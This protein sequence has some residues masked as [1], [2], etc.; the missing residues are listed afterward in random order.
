MTIGIHSTDDLSP[1]LPGVEALD[2][3]FDKDPHPTLFKLLPL[4]CR[5][6]SRQANPAP[7]A[8]RDPSRRAALQPENT[9]QDFRRR[10]A[11]RELERRQGKR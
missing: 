9:L 11:V 7:L 2:D 1:E 8:L 6:R 4:Q 5:V 10:L 3:G